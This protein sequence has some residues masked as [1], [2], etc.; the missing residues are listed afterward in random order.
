MTSSAWM[1]AWGPPWVPFDTLRNWSVFSSTIQSSLRSISAPLNYWL[2]NWPQLLGI[3]PSAPTISHVR[4]LFSL[5][6]GGNFVLLWLLVGMCIEE[7]IWHCG[8]FSMDSMDDHDDHSELLFATH[9]D[10]IN[11]GT[12]R[13]YSMFSCLAI[14]LYWTLLCLGLRHPKLA[15]PGSVVEQQP[16]E[17]FT[18][19]DSFINT[20]RHNYSYIYI[21]IYKVIHKYR[22]S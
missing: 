16:N 2:N 13:V 7:P 18:C 22:N 14:L 15:D 8:E 3:P 19:R 4:Y 10:H 6:S 12:K 5:Q 21:Y 9:C 20:Q 1:I 17:Q 11:G